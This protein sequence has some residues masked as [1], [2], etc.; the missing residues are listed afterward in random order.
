MDPRCDPVRF[1]GGDVI[2]GSVRNAGGRITD[3]AIRSIVV[4]RSLNTVSEGGTVAVVH[5]T[6]TSAY[7]PILT[8]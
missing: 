6:G 5:H 1:L 7:N 8:T 3:D 4:L 2:F